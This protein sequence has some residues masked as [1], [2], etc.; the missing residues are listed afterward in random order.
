MAAL[1]GAVYLS[2]ADT[3][4]VNA[5]KLIRFSPPVDQYYVFL[6]LILR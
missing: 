6:P 4:T 3:R 2:D 5:G 1:G